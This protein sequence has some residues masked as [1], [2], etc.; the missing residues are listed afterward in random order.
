MNLQTYLDTM[1][2][3]I[4]NNWYEYRLSNNKAAMHYTWCYA[5]LLTG[6]RKKA[7]RMIEKY[8]KKRAEEEA[9]LTAESYIED[10]NNFEY[11]NAE[12]IDLWD[13]RKFFW[14]EVAKCVR[15]W[16]QLPDKSKNIVN[17]NWH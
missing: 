4:K 11:Y 17:L 14:L 12:K 13:K 10:I 8:G 7:Y 16:A 5:Q 3:N 1:V 2:Q 6:S 15:N 9:I